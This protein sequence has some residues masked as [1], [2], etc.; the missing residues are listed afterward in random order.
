LTIF[1]IHL[2]NKSE[3]SW[4]TR[5]GLCDPKLLTVVYFALTCF[6]ISWFS[7]LIIPPQ[8]KKPNNN[9]MSE[10]HK[11]CVKFK[12]TLSVQCKASWKQSERAGSQLSV[13]SKS[14]VMHS[15]CFG[16]TEEQVLFFLFYL[17]RHLLPERRK[18]LSN[19][20]FIYKATTS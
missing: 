7:V 11:Q 2:I 15:I 8:I 3:F 18:V 12:H 20:P 19:H 5:N 14:C 9:S 1:S 13:N 16:E 17:F 4:K 10:G 6:R